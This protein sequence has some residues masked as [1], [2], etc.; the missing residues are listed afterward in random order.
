MLPNRLAW[1]PDLPMTMFWLPCGPLA[2]PSVWLTSVPGDAICSASG[3]V[4]STV[5]PTDGG[6]EN[7]PG[8][9]CDEYG[10]GCDDGP[11]LSELPV[12]AEASRRDG[13]STPG[14]TGT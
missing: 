10:N 1:P 9:L 7:V 5:S 11:R 6:W 13:S 14:L 2:E 8:V 3:A 12:A 4:R